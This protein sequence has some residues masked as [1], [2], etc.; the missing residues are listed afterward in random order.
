MILE[1]YSCS[2]R[3]MQRKNNEDNL[4]FNGLIKDESSDSFRHY[5]KMNINKRRAVFGVFDGMGGYLNG[6]HASYLTADCVK[7]FLKDNKKGDPNELLKEIAFYAEEQVCEEVGQSGQKMGS[8]LAMLYF[9]KN[10]YSLCNIGDSPIYIIRK[11]E[12]KRISTEHTEAAA[13]EKIYG[14]KPPKNK[15]F[16]L[17]QYVG[18]G[19]SITQL[20]PYYKHGSVN[21]GDIFLICSDGLTD[22][23]DDPEISRIINSSRPLADIG[24]ILLKNSNDKGGDDNIT[25][26]LIRATDV[27]ESK[28]ENDD[29]AVKNTE[30]PAARSKEPMSRFDSTT[31]KKSDVRT[32]PKDE[33]SHSEKEYEYRSIVKIVIGT[34]IF[35]VIVIA[36]SFITAL[37]V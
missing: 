24:K 37:R 28:D 10:N 20:S 6:E 1:A 18:M 14:E 33:A 7:S 17:T 15:K 5:E 9:E 19:E 27:S 3:G 21:E 13:Y 34:V 22:M 25:F 29:N 36:V 23:L 2:D 12:L 35:S 26:I 4:Y 11:G 31:A 30:S 32:K 8:T 16:P